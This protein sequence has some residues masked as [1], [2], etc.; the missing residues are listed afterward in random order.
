MSSFD[1]NTIFNKSLYAKVFAV[2]LGL[3]V[4]GLFLSF[5]YF[6]SITVTDTIGTVISASIVAFMVQ[7]IL[8]SRKNEM[9]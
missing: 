2:I 3:A 8:L 1:Q 6:G 9:S 7:L 5:L 4:V